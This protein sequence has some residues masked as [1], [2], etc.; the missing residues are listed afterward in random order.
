MHALG[1]VGLS[2]SGSSTN[3]VTDEIH[4]YHQIGYTFEDRPETP[5]NKKI[6]Y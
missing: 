1:S 4:Q 2:H 6:N 3:C 5:K